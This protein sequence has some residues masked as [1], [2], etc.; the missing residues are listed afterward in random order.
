MCFCVKPSA[1]IAFVDGEEFGIV[2]LASLYETPSKQNYGKNRLRRT[3]NVVDEEGDCQ[4]RSRHVND[5]GKKS[6]PF[7]S[8]RRF[9]A[10][11]LRHSG[12]VYCSHEKLKPF[13]IPRFSQSNAI[14]FCVSCSRKIITID[15][16]AINGKKPMKVIEMKARPI[17]E[18]QHE[19]NVKSEGNSRCK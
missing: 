19:Q 12:I 15:L 16:K 11:H 9:S 14:L 3:V 2:F 8:T 17:F 5:K 1:C 18:K 7:D 13:N 4:N 6:Q 10:H